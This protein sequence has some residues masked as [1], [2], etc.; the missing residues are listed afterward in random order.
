MKKKYYYYS[1]SNCNFTNYIMGKWNNSYT[2]SQDLWNYL[3]GCK[4][5]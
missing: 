4:F 3:Y 1:F 2:N 5:S